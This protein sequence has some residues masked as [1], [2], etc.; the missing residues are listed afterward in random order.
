ME[1]RPLARRAGLLTKALGDELL[2]YDLARRRAHG[3]N[4][5]AAALWRACDGRRAGPELVAAVRETAGV[6]VTDASVAYGVAALARAGLLAR[7][8]RPATRVSRRQVLARLGAAAAL[9]AVVSLVAP[10]AAQAQSLPPGFDACVQDS[11]CTVGECWV[12]GSGS[13]EPCPGPGTL[14]YC[15]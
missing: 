5:P 12:F 6:P 7:P 15:E 14:C 10:T 2:V 3:L 13:I 11:D 8:A 1:S 4:A 9:P